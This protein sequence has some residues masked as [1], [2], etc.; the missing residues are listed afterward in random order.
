MKKKTRWAPLAGVLLSA[1]N[2]P[3]G[4]IGLATTT[5]LA[6]IRAESILA[7]M[8]LLFALTHAAQSSTVEFAPAVISPVAGGPMQLVLGDF[9]GDGKP[10]L[11]V[12]S[13]R[14]STTS[15]LLGN[16]DGTFHA[17]PN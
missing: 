10:D 6:S 17:K 5:G 12:V 7:A 13:P 11:A 8:F 4:K 14:T 2:V 15:I 3:P 1:L 9:S 16:G